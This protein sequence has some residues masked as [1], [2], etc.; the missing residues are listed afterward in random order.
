MPIFY[1]AGF[2]LHPRPA[3]LNVS[4]PEVGIDRCLTYVEPE[5]LLE[6]SQGHADAFGC[7]SNICLTPV[8]EV[9]SFL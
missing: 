5:R 2:K 3:D 7:M 4:F 9:Q 6:I 1:R 8:A